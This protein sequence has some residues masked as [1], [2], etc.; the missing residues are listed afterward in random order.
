MK[1]HYPKLK[2]LKLT[3]SV[4]PNERFIVAQNFNGDSDIKVLL[5]TTAV[6]G[7]GLNLSSANTVIMFDH[8][9][10]PTVDIQAIDRAHRIGQKRVLNVY[11]LITKNTLEER[12]MGIQ[13][14]KQNLAQAIV[15]IDNAS[16]KNIEQSKLPEL[17]ENIKD[18]E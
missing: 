2:Y 15:N 6:G 9:Y 3:A 18:L 4:K 14:F 12:I 1:V 11:R 8:D 5:V 7:E 16:I 13:K 10:N 17:L